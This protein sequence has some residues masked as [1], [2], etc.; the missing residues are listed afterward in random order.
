[1]KHVYDEMEQYDTQMTQAILL[2]IFAFVIGLI[3][4]GL[5]D[6]YDRYLENKAEGCVLGKNG[7]D[8]VG[9]KLHVQ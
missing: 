3:V 1:M 5:C 4:S 7:N 8:G 9:A 2:T 6:Q